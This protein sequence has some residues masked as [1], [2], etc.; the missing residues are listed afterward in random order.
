M[1][2]GMGLRPATRIRRLA[3]YPFAVLSGRVAALRRQGIEPVDFGVGDPTLPTPALVRERAQRAIDERADTGYPSYIGAPEFRRAAA[4]WMRRVLGCDLDPETQITA[5]IGSKEAIFHFPLGF[6][7]PGEV[8]LCP[9]PGYPPYVR[10]TLFAGGTPHLLP[11]DREHG[12]LP[13][14]DAVP[15]EV[16][17]RARI[18]WL[19]SPNAPT[20]VV[21]PPEFLARAVAWGRTRG[22]IVVND[23]AYADL[24]YGASRPASILEQ[25]TDGVAAFFSLSKR[26]A[27][28]G[29]RVGWTAGDPELIA[30]FRKVKTNLDSG[31]PTFIQDA[32]AA[33][34]RDEAHVEAFRAGYKAKRDLLAEAF[35]ALGLERC[36]PEATIHYWQK[37]PQGV[38][39]VKFAQRLL[40][41][42]LAVVATPGPW[43][44]EPLTDGRNPGAGYVRFSMV[45]SLEAT[46]RACAALKEHAGYLL[47]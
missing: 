11:L 17:A 41:P 35:E 44:A 22:V 4:N 46:A 32:A 18:L 6:V 3:D 33:A 26:S 40:D 38:D 39:A 2:P 45:P 21:A 24:Y 30:V 16:A 12:Y 47:G 1:I 15:E 34:L 29:W 37:L 7:D 27:M 5:T 8:V 28:T 36:V 14:L 23:E 25:G 20:G 9:S 42:R 43:I 31:T 13:D 10:G 19:C